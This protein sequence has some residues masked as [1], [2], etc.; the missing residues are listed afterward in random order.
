MP[1]HF[2][3][4]QI[5]LNKIY[6]VQHFLV[7]WICLKFWKGLRLIAREY[8]FTSWQNSFT[9]SKDKVLRKK[10]VF[11]PKTLDNTTKKTTNQGKK[12]PTK[13]THKTK[14]QQNKSNKIKK[15]NNKSQTYNELWKYLQ[16]LC[17]FTV[18]LDHWKSS[19]VS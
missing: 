12:K 17:S 16:K 3:P 19:S 13:K 18:F 5:E 9:D 1:S 4:C 6:A 8:M 11:S 14:T 7:S 2:E 10:I 15:L